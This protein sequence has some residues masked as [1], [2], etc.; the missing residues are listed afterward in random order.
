MTMTLTQEQELASISS[1][2]Q[3]LTASTDHFMESS[4]PS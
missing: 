2:L 3:Q 1:K 4:P